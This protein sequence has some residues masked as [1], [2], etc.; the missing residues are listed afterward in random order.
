MSQRRNVKD[1]TNPARS[2]MSRVNDVLDTIDA[3][4]AL[5]DDPSFRNAQR[6]VKKLKKMSGQ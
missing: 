3:A 2:A 4:A 5:G 6:L 1:L